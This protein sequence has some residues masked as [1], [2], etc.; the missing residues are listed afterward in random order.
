MMLGEND[1]PTE[2]AKRAEDEFAV[3]PVALLVRL[4]VL[5]V[6]DALTG[7]EGLLNMAAKP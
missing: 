5:S 6:V 4:S 1:G 3:K 2:V 7:D